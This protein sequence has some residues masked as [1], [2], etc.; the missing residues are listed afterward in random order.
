M[1]AWSYPVGHVMALDDALVTRVPER[2]GSVALSLRLRRALSPGLQ[3]HLTRV[4]QLAQVLGSS[5]GLSGPTLTQLRLGASLHDVGKAFVPASILNK[6]GPLT[7]AERRVME[8]HVVYGAALANRHAPA[9]LDIITC[10]HEHWDGRG[11]RRGL[12]GEAIP[13][14][15]RVTA[16]AD[17]YDAMTNDRPYRR[18]LSHGEAL[19]ILQRAAGSQ[20]DPYLAGAF[21][22]LFRSRFASL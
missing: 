12:R 6:P 17:A 18:R 8:R 15:A 13:Y 1:L 11:Y 3:A 4:G 10:H 7:G 2:G 5:L 19:V 20:F 22:E 9:I 16:I 14:L 21:V